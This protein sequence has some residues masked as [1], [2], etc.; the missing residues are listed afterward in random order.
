MQCKL[1][2]VKCHVRAALLRYG[3]DVEPTNVV[4]WLQPMLSSA[5]CAGQTHHV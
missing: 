1:V 4:E 3:A 2:T 5:S